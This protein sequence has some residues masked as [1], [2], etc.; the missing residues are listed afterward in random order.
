[1]KKIAAV[2]SCLVTFSAFAETAP[3]KKMDAVDFLVDRDGLRGKRVVVTG[4]HIVFAQ[5]AHVA[6]AAFPGRS[7]F[8]IDGKSMEREGLRYALRHCVEFDDANDCRAEVSGVV[9]EVLSE[10]G[11]RDA[12]LKWTP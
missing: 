9:G 11:L 6:C 1:M 10:A 12:T 5:A 2:L 4:C 8:Y 3:P 7:M